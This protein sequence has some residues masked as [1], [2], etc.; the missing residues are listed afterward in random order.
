MF[1]HMEG[2]WRE[3]AERPVPLLCQCQSRGSRA[4]V[5]CIFRH[6]ARAEQHPAALYEALDSYCRAGER[7]EQ[8]Q[9]V[10]PDGYQVVRLKATLLKRK[11]AR[12]ST[13]RRRRQVN[14]PFHSK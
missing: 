6:E 13:T 5:N 2:A 9:C 8:Q 1:I 12:P 3:S 7:H 4:P 11:K 14:A 10:T